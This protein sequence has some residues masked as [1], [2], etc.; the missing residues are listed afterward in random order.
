MFRFR[1][2]SPWLGVGVLAIFILVADIGTYV[3]RY[4]GSPRSLKINVATLLPNSIRIA[5]G[6]VAEWPNGGR[7]RECRMLT[8]GE[9]T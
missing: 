8:G 3:T 7:M 6:L 5:C 1:R 9:Q 4:G 2:A